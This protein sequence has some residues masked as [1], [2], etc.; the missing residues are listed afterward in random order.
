MKEAPDASSADIPGVNYK[1][2]GVNEWLR[3]TKDGPLTMFF[4]FVKASVAL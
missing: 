4:C 3:A 2:L 1:G